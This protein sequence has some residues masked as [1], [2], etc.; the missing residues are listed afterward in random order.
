MYLEIT[1]LKRFPDSCRKKAEKGFCRFGGVLRKRVAAKK[2]IRAWRNAPLI[3]SVCGGVD[4]RN[5]PEGVAR[6]LEEDDV[7]Q[8]IIEA[9]WKRLV[10]FSST[11]G[12]TFYSASEV[13]EIA[14]HLK[15][16]FTGVGGRRAF[17][18]LADDKI[19]HLVSG[20][21][22]KRVT[23][24]G[25]LF[26]GEEP[27]V[28]VFDAVGV[29]AADEGSRDD[30]YCAH[31]WVDTDRLMHNLR[32]TQNAPAYLNA[33]VPAL[34]RTVSTVAPAD[35][36]NNVLAEAVY[37]EWK[38]EAVCVD[39]MG[40]FTQPLTDTG[41]LLTRKAVLRLCRAIDESM[42][43]ASGRAWMA[44]HVETC[45]AGLRKFDYFAEMVSHVSS[46]VRDVA[47][48]PVAVFRAEAVR[49]RWGAG[50]SAPDRADVLNLIARAMGPDGATQKPHLQGLEVAVRTDRAGVFSG[51]KGDLDDA[52][53]TIFLAG[54]RAD[55]HRVAEAL[56]APDKP[57][58]FGK[59]AYLP[60]ARVN[61]VLTEEYTSLADAVLRYPLAARSDFAI[62]N[63]GGI[64]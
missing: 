21:V 62:R 11:A 58:F 52:A 38:K 12:E 7:H 49:M 61:C 59:P 15:S 13:R 51:K 42:G 18:S 53:F 29:S 2:L 60:C 1:L 25:A 50:K 57:V 24:A 4:A 32:A 10:N 39:L 26:D 64:S 30:L 36:A 35:G 45:P 40:A 48:V 23:L 8:E 5:L 6:A 46:W 14:R 3:A 22:Q 37:F 56:A 47:R 63:N 43:A 20:C 44:A 54:A 55:L 19:R 34:L 41:I 31:I 17:E 16:L 28:R 27:A 33:L 9:I